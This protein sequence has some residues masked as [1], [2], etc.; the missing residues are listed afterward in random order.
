MHAG[1]HVWSCALPRHSMLPCRRH[2]INHTSAPR[3]ESNPRP[4]QIQDRTVWRSGSQQ[5]SLNLMLMSTSFDL[6]DSVI[7]FERHHHHH[8]HY[9]YYYYYYY[10]S[11]EA[12]GVMWSVVMSCH[13]R[14]SA[15]T[16]LMSVSRITHD[17]DNGRRPNMVDMGKGWPSRS[18]YILVLIRIPMWI[19]DHY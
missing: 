4:R 6:E 1:S 8:H 10:Y 19:L 17:R 14:T 11:A 2:I 16:S 7:R 5:L 15:I 18:G 12:D 3:L 13:P 9:Y